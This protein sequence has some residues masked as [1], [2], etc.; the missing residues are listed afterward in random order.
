MLALNEVSQR[1]QKLGVVDSLL[2]RRH[3]IPPTLLAGRL[4]RRIISCQWP[5]RLTTAPQYNTRA[6]PARRV[7]LRSSRCS[8]SARAYLRLLPNRSRN[9]A[10]V[11]LPVV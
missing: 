4:L 6:S 9:W 10:T 2:L 7:I 8:S 11:I 5:V 3:R 1:A